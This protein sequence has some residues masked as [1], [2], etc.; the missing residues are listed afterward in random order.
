MKAIAVRP[1]FFGSSSA[2]FGFAER[3]WRGNPAYCVLFGGAAGRARENP[4]FPR[5]SEVSAP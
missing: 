5:G 4:R 3:S 1:A 2:G